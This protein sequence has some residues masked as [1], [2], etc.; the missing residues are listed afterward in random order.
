MLEQTRPLEAFQAL[1]VL[2]TAVSSLR[3]LLTFK[4]IATIKVDCSLSI[5]RELWCPFGRRECI[6]GWYLKVDHNY[7]KRFDPLTDATIVCVID[8]KLYWQVL[9]STICHPKN[10][11][12]FARGEMAHKPW[13]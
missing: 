10:L 8:G 6:L 12:V 7:V 1:C 13:G 5:D 2:A 11:A 4:C 3:R 9:C